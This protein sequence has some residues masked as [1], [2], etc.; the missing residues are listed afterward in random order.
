MVLDL[1]LIK[2]NNKVPFSKTAFFSKINF[3]FEL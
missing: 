3:T 2:Y 1:Q